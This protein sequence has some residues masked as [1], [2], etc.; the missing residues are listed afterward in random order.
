MGELEH[1]SRTAKIHVVE[2]KCGEL[3]KRRDVAC[4]RAAKLV[5]AEVELLERRRERCE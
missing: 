4:D 3:G 2:R 1:P 5:A